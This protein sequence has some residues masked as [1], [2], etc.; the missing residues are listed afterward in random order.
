MLS[1]IV[2][3]VST[4]EQHHGIR[5]NLVFM[6]ETHYGFLREE[7]PG[8]RDHDDVTNIIGVDIA[9]SDEALRPHVATVT[10][11]TNHILSS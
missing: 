4:Y 6:N 2:S 1:Y 7:L 11:G 3:L 8:V 9:L 5:P 10:F